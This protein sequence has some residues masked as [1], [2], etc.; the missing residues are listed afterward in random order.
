MKKE[1]K[2]VFVVLVYRNYGDLSEFLESIKSTLKDAYECIVVDS[3]YSD[4]VSDEVKRIS[5][6]F[7]CDYLCVENHG[8]GAG[9]NRGIEYALEHYDFSY[10]IISNPDIIL[11][12]FQ[13]GDLKQDCI[14]PIILTAKGKKQNPHWA[15]RNKLVM[16]VMNYGFIKQKKL[17]LYLGIAI[18]KVD[19]I[20]WR[21]KRD[22]LKG[23]KTNKIYSPH[24]SFVLLKKEV[25]QSDAFRFD[26]E[27][28]L[29]FEEAVLGEF[30]YQRGKNVSYNDSIRVLHKE[31]GSIQLSN[32]NTFQHSGKSFQHF[33]KNYICEKKDK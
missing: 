29:F 26:E 28:F 23:E 19:K 20:V 25:L 22:L 6:H 31:D 2:Y 21:I 33:Y 11:E 8:Y 14:A 3:F 17:F 16:K 18:G 30:L 9:N 5:Q 32:V 15:R 4:E 13:I 24:G 1:T 27:M 7:A 10:M 12:E